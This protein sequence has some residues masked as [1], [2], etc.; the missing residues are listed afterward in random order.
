MENLQFNI[1]D[2]VAAGVLLVSA[3]VAFWRGFVKEVLL[4]AALVGAGIAAYRGYPYLQ[5][6]LQPYLADE[7]FATAAAGGII[8]LVAMIVLSI[9]FGLIIKAVKASEVGGFDR[10]LGFLFGLVRGALLIALAYLILVQFIPPEEHPDWVREARARPAMQ[11][12]AD[13]LIRLAPPDMAARLAPVTG[14]RPKTELEERTRMLREL[15]PPDS[16][17]ETGY[18]PEDRRQLDRLLGTSKESQ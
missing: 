14:E 10:S 9:I 15:L 6:Y 11:Y 7:R 8:F 16:G 4:I 3:L 18:K 1:L 2:L 17:D 13:L 5:P 12:G